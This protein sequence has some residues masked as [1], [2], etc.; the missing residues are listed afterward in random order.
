MALDKIA[1]RTQRVSR[2]LL[3]VS[4]ALGVLAVII[5]LMQNS[6][7]KPLY[8]LLVAQVVTFFLMFRR[9]VWAI[10]S[11]IIGQFTASNYMMNIGGLVI[12]AR[13]LWT[14]LVL[15][16]LVPVLINARSIIGKKGGLL[17]GAV[18]AF[19]AW[20]LIAN[21]INTD[22][23]TTVSFL[24]QTLTAL[25]IVLITPLLVK[26]KQDIIIILV[27]TAIIGAVSA[28]TGILQHYSFMGMP[29]FTL[30]PNLFIEGRAVGLTYSPVH[31]AYGLPIIMVGMFAYYL[32]AK[33][34]KR[35]K[36]WL[37][38]LI[39]LMGLAL[40]FT[41][42]RSGALAVG[43]GALA[44]VLG[45]KGKRRMQFLVVLIIIAALFFFYIGIK[46]S[47]YTPGGEKE[48]SAAA[49]SILWPAAME[50]AKNNPM[51]G[52]GYDKFNTQAIEYSSVVSKGYNE[53]LVTYA[54]GRLQPHNDFL[55]VWVSF[56]TPA[57]IAF[58][59]III[60]VFVS[61]LR[62]YVA[63]SEPLIKAVCLGLIGAIPAYIANAATHNMME[64]VF[65]LWIIC[66]MAIALRRMTSK[67]LKVSSVKATGQIANHSPAQ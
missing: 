60:G 67:E 36:K 40:Y 46:Q 19:F 31:L 35:T 20:T 12:S 5:G 59:L 16:V 61:L 39:L 51:F 45:L 62:S 7:E 10:V 65:I 22:F 14:V 2:P 24:R 34:S 25:T 32:K 50:I 43:V 15:L 3:V 30:T 44:V 38:F 23:S 64:S 41:Y 1:I 28:F 18:L 55:M 17:L 52:L 27:V 54:L 26:D 8:F 29:V 6:M 13:F 56:G 11:L 48:G 53:G 57:F 33:P 21:L 66:G 63:T 47:R 9:R 42:T 37:I 4:I 49:R 58:I